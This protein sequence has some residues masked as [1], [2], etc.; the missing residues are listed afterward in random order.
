MSDLSVVAKVTRPS[1][2][3][4]DLDINDHTY[5]T[6]AGQQIMGGTVQ[7]DRK[8]VSAPWVDGDVTVARR[9]G[10]V[11]ENLTVYVAGSTQAD[12]NT[13][14]QNLIGAFTQDRYTLSITIGS[15]QYAW[16]CETADYSVQFDTPHL[17]SLYVAA[18]FSIP[19]KPVALSGA[20]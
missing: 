3:L 17:H 6:I 12:L 14:L 18:T 13:N 15:Q 7:W 11:M 9:R 2:G 1:L 8:Q 10:N 19:R 4:P 5:Y 20:F 16:D